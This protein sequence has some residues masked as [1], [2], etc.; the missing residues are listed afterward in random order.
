M[1]RDMSKIKTILD[2]KGD[3]SKVLKNYIKHWGELKGFS[4]ALQTGKKNLG[5]TATRLNRMIGFGP[6][7]PNLS[8]VTDIDSSGNYVRDQGSSWDE[9]M[10]HMVKV[11]KLL[12][13]KFKIK[14]KAKDESKKLS[15]LTKSLGGGSSAE[16]D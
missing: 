9:Y 14:A 5:D 10:L 2:A 3:A 4:L 13:D 15:E 8:Q 12:A 11:Q 1:Y 16:N 6:L 7:M